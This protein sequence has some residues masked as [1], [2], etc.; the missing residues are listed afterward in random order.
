MGRCDGLSAPVTQRAIQIAYLKPKIESC[1]ES[2]WVEPRR[3]SFPAVQVGGCFEL[4][5]QSE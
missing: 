4:A 2:Q 3:S 1:L 5:T